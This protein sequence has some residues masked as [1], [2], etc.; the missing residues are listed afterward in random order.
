MF[1]QEIEKIKN[2]DC[3]NMIELL[4]KLSIINSERISSE[5]QF[6]NFLTETKNILKLENK[7][8]QVIIKVP[9]LKADEEEKMLTQN[10]QFVQNLQLE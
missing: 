1:V 7:E 2:E 3:T 5:I 10:L 6:E 4:R 8:N 9:L